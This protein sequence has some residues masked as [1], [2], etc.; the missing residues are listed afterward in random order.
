MPDGVTVVLSADILAT[1]TTRLATS[2]IPH[3]PGKVEL[4]L[5]PDLIR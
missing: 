4:G 2:Q 3:H 1:S 5:I